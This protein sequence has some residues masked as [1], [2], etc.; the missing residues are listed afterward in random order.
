MGYGGEERRRHPR[1][2]GRFVVHYRL[3]E[4]R[5]NVDITQTKNIS[6][7]GMYLT[8]NKK[9]ASGTK[10]TL[11][12]RLPFD[13]HPIMIIGK[14]LESYEVAKNLIYDTRLEFLAIDERH[15]NIISQTVDFYNKKRP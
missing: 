10:L 6:L 4:E 3:F 14:V 15:S 8:T 7:G 2:K 12:I 13:P 9:F 5:D 1:A 11:E